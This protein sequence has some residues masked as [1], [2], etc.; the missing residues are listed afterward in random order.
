MGVIIGSLGVLICVLTGLAGPAGVDKLVLLIQP[1]EFIVIAGS[2]FFTVI[3]STPGRIIKKLIP[4]IIGAIK[5]SGVSKQTYTDL[6]GL[7]ACIFD[8]IR[9]E[10][11]LGVEADIADPK[12]SARFQKYPAASNNHHIME[13]F[14]GSL[15]LFV[16]GVVNSFELEKMLDTEIE[17]HHE[18]ESACSSLVSRT[19]DSFPALGIVAAVLGIIITMQALSEGPDAIGHHVAAALT[20]T[21]LGILLGYGFVSPVA[22]KMENNTN[23]ISTVLKTL[24][25]GLVAFSGGTSPQVALEFARKKIPSDMRPTSEELEEIIRAA[26]AK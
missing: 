24:Q 20:G 19:A 4:A 23:D 15:R 16:D 13:T 3:T 11:A 22:A 14:I 17:T 7:M 1:F 21:F 12:A 25:I 9:K 26:K 5:G 10:G 8:V 18:E 2:A 6:L